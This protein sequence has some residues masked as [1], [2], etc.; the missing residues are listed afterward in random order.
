MKAPYHSPFFQMDPVKDGGNGPPNGNVC[1]VAHY[2]KFKFY[3][4][5]P[6]L[7]V[8]STIMLNYKNNWFKKHFQDCHC[9][10]N[11]KVTFTQRVKYD[12]F[13][14]SDLFDVMDDKS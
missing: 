4:I 3:A 12:L 5:F 14:I 6:T 1:T 10:P 8:T 9:Q 13:F 7:R 2:Y 11:K